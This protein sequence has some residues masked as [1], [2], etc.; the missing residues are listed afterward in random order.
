[1]S[2]TALG[3]VTGKNSNCSLLH[4]GRTVSRDMTASRE[5]FGLE[6]KAIIEC[7]TN[8]EFSIQSCLESMGVSLL[9]DWDMLVFV[10][11]HGASLT[12]TD[13]IARLIGYEGAVVAAALDRLER[14]KLIERLGPPQGVSLLR[15]STEAGHWRCLQQLVNL[16]ETRVGRLL[17]TKLLKPVPLE[18]DREEPSIKSENEGA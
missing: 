6:D 12:S 7:E 3:G 18:S 10:Y 2:I 14:N 13:Q 1:M 9:S 8:S 16:T 15:I 11:R 5:K 17:L 4:R